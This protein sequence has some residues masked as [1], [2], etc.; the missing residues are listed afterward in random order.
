MLRIFFTPEDLRRIR[1]AAG[2]DP[3]W[4]ILL[5]LHLL[6]KRDGAVLFD[7]WRAEVRGQFPAEARMLR[8]LAPPWGY[9]PDFLTPAAGAAGLDAGIDL[10]LATPHRL[11]QHDLALLAGGHRPGPGLRALAAGEPDALH[12]LGT[13]LRRYHDVALAPHWDRIR[14]RVEADRT[15]RGRALLDGGCDRLLRGLHPAIHWE[16][17]VLRVEY[18]FGERALH[19]DGRG[20]LLLPSFFCVRDP[21]T[22]RDPELPPVLVYPV[23]HELGWATGTAPAARHRPLAALLGRTRAAVLET[24]AAGCTTG[25]LARRLRISAASASEHATVLRNA[26]LITTHRYRNTSCHT[27]TRLGTDLLHSDRGR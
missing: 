7:Q 1:I 19:L 5:S 18:G 26:G 22:L 2:P 27:L 24:V 9:S 20:L 3:L 21:I 13:A 10:L 23:E 25:E 15:G 6:G 14:A 12:R 8:V 16:P 17:P 4:E 11:R